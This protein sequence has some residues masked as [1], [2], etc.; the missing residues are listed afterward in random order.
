[1]KI[2]KTILIISVVIWITFDKSA[3]YAQEKSNIYLELS[4]PLLEY[5]L[6]NRYL[7]DAGHRI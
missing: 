6:F 2:P 5:S 1:M 7:F 4:K 3:I